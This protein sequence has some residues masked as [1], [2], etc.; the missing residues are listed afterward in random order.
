MY[1]Q[2]SKRLDSILDMT[3]GSIESSNNEIRE[4]SQYARQEYEELEEEFLQLKIDAGALID[5]VEA[6]DLAYR[7][8]R[9]KLLIINKNHTNYTEEEMKAIYEETDSL[10]IKL[11]VEKER[12]NNIINRRN[13]LE[14]HLKSIRKIS[15]KADKLNNDFELVHTILAGNLKQIT[16]KIDDI[17]NKEYWG[18]KVIQGQEEERQRI[19]R[20]MHDGPAQSLSNLIIK[21]ELC[22][23]L[24]DK[25]IDRTKLELQ[26]LKSLIRGTIDETRRLIYNL[27]PMSIDDLGVFATISRYIEKISNESK[28]DISFDVGKNLQEIDLNEALSITVFRILQESL[29][30]IIKYAETSHVDIHIDTD[31]H[32]LNLTIQD[33]GKGFDVDQA[34]ESRTTTSGFG[35]TMMKERIN[36]LNGEFNIKSSLGKGT[37]INIKLSIESLKEEQDE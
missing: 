37:I 30:N 1:N 5:R 7:K 11:A 25:D 16:E 8:S 6:L 27:R 20:D 19:A 32:L 33:Y 24:L 21:T 31:D 3:I 23:K 14:I 29:N 4:I 34:F 13:E 9:A 22:I 18:L 17:K 15:E 26:T 10:R 2:E 36:L 28:I 35:L 12:E